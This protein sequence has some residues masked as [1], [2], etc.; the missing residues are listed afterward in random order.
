M[1][2]EDLIFALDIGTRTVVGLILEPTSGGLEIIATEVAEHENRAM[3]DGQIHNVIEVAKVVQQIK[4]KLEEQIGQELTKVAVA[5][6]GRAL[7]TAKQT[8]HIEYSSKREITSEDVITIEMAAVQQAQMNLAEDGD[9]DPTDYHFVG[10]SVIAYRLD[11]MHIGNLVGQKGKKIEVDLISTFLPR[12]VVDS[13]ITVLQHADLTIQHMTLEP[14]AASNVVIPKEMHNFNL[15][16]VDIGAGTSDIAITKGGAITAYAMVPVAGDEIT[17][18]LAEQYLLDYSSSEKLKRS[19]TKKEIISLTDILGMS[20]DINSQDAVIVLKQP[21]E[22]LANLIGEE[23]LQLNE[24]A[25]Q[26][27][28]CIGGGSLTPLLTQ[29]LAAKLGLPENRVGVKQA[30]D[31]KGIIGEIPNL[32]SAQA[33]TPIGIAVTCKD[34]LTR[35]TFIDIKINGQR[36]NLFSLGHPTISDALLASDIP[37][38]KLHGKPGLAL[39]AKV[40]GQLKTLK[41]TMGEP[42]QLKLNGEPTTLDTAIQNGDEIIYHPGTDGEPGCGIV[43]DVI[44]FEEIKTITLNGSMNEVKTHVMMNDKL[45][46]PDTPLEDGAEIRYTT[47][48]NY[49]EALTILLEIPA[50]DLISREIHFSLNNRQVTRNIGKYRIISNNNLD[51]DQPVTDGTEIEVQAN[52]EQSLT[53]ADLTKEMNHTFE[54]EIIFNGRELSIPT[55]HWEI[56][57]NGEEVTIDTNV[58]DGDKI[59]CRPKPISFNQI[60]SYI[61]YQLPKSLSGKLTMTI[62][63]KNANFTDKVTSGDILEI[64]IG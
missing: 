38:R 17:E 4:A 32:A 27:V 60:L 45:V 30:K 59:I 10:Y 50:S 49:R 31:I 14:I 35:T 36:C 22:E 8:H 34:N 26:A 12:I 48:K 13:L 11:D 51:L 24:K 54:I 61:N 2:R 18:A 9:H 20:L 42:G 3:L 41:G 37:I 6:A 16:L 43:S 57:K 56:S 46:G 53:I 23:I 19:I 29:K 62:N 47:P 52:D 39:T 21:V 58:E 1:N 33:I 44:P 15:A 5:A 25:P 55:N 7:K 40:N 64:D 28:L 63:G